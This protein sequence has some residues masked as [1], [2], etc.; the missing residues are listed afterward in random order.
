[1][2]AQPTPVA[3]ET[4]TFVAPGGTIADRWK[5]GHAAAALAS[6]HWDVLVLQ[7]RGGLLA[8]MVDPEQRTQSE[9][10]ASD[11]AH[12]DFAA[13]AKAAKTNGAQPT[14]GKRGKRASKRVKAKA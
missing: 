8:C 12:R 6:G 5:D 10:R 9:C 11:R 1:M 7:E 13:K 3:I 14:P 2:V 4:Q